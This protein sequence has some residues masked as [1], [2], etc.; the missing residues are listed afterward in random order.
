MVAMNLA[1]AWLLSGGLQKFCKL[2]SGL[3]EIKISGVTA[4]LLQLGKTQP[5]A[6]L[7][8]ENC[9]LSKLGN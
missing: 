4:A 9:P 8:L 2:W 1:A 7:Y 6:A 3:A 5:A